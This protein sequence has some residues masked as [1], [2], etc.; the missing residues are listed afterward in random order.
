MLYT[1]GYCCLSILYSLNLLTPNFHSIP[2]FLSSHRFVLYVCESLSLMS[3]FRSYIEVISYGIC[4]SDV[5]SAQILSILQFDNQT[6]LTCITSTVLRK[7]QNLVYNLHIIIFQ[8]G[9]FVYFIF[10]QASVN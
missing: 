2:P 9:D 6:S 10:L 4:L 7:V 3:Y 8:K 5:R 1:S